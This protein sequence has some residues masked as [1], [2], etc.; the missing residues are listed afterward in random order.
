MRGSLLVSC[1]GVIRSRMLRQLRVEIGKAGLQLAAQ[2]HPGLHLPPPNHHLDL[3]HHHHHS[4]YLHRRRH[5]CALHRK[6]FKRIAPGRVL[7]GDARFSSEVISQSS[8]RSFVRRK[9]N[10]N[11]GGN[12]EPGWLEAK[13]KTRQSLR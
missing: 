4:T 9:S 2:L 8:G 13:I 12:W 3:I 10:I 7:G 6:F 5:L 1:L 11:G